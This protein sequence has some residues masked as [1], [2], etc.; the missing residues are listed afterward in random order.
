VHAS[1]ACANDYK[2]RVLNI[3]SAR[4]P[5]HGNAFASA[6]AAHRRHQNGVMIPH[7]SKPP[8]S[9]RGPAGPSAGLPP[10]IRRAGCLAG[11]C[12]E[13]AIIFMNR[14]A[15]SGFTD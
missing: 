1:N 14:P 10:R 4:C 5:D 9:Q 13:T 12:A 7:N 6:A 3:P 15:E 2:P 11:R 8:F